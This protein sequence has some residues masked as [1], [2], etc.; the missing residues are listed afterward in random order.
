MTQVPHSTW[1]RYGSRRTYQARFV[2][3]TVATA[4]SVETGSGTWYRSRSVRVSS[5]GAATSISMIWNDVKA[6]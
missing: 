5:A 4:A 1:P 6:K 2:P 3:S